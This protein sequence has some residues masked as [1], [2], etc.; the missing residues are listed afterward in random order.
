MYPGDIFCSAC[1]GPC[2]RSCRILAFW[3]CLTRWYSFMLFLFFGYLITQK[4]LNLY[5]NVCS[6]QPNCGFYSNRSVRLWY[7]QRKLGWVQFHRWSSATCGSTVVRV[8]STWWPRARTA[9]L[10][11]NKKSPWLVASQLKCHQTV[12][13]MLHAA[14]VLQ[15]TM[16]SDLSRTAF[17]SC[18]CGC[19]Q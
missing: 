14:G 1:W 5:A 4:M 9:L 17:L 15:R 11:W 7:L 8:R 6:R 2:G 18:Q 12:W 16:L 3:Q 13:V 10:P 19:V